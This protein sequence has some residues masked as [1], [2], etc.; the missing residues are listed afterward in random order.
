[1]SAETAEPSVMIDGE[2]M[3]G[4]GRF[5]AALLRKDSSLQVWKLTRQ[6]DADALANEAMDRGA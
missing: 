5:I 4:V 1:M 2:I 6:S 3:F